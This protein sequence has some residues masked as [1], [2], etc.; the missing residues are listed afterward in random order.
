[1]K[2]SILATLSYSD[3]FDY[4][5]TEEEI[6]QW[7]ISEDGRHLPA[8]KAGRT[9][10]G[11]QKT[12]DRK[13]FAHSLQLVLDSHLISVKEGFYCLKGR[14]E[15]FPIRKQRDFW[16]KPKI[17]RAEKVAVILR[18]I[19]WI[20]LIG[21]TGGLARNNVDEEDDID[22]FFIAAQNRLWLTRGIVVLIL[23]FL[24]LYRRPNKFKDMICPNMFVAESSLKMEPEDIFTAHEVCLLKPIFVRGDI[25][26]KFLIENRWVEKF[27][28]NVL[29][30]IKQ[31]SDLA[32]EK[33]KK[34]NFLNYLIT[35][36]LNILEVFARK[37]QLWYM[38][39]K[40]TT[41]LVSDNLI[42]FH[43]QDARNWVLE[44]YQKRLKIYGLD[45]L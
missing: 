45:N 35:Q 10:D 14:E 3:I 7:L 6:W 22:L 29:K 12:E 38:R 43:P 11:K 15:I 16:S 26:Q 2:S 19:P 17:R 21:I 13:A 40:R 39:K 37:L 44:E 18:L 42:K 20:K 9:E 34:E 8:G 33:G 24:G 23:S 41:E 4:P 31:L 30:D 36:L 1:M 25:Y 32:I 27:L 5:L 28:P